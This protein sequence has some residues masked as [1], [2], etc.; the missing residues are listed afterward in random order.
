MTPPKKK[1]RTK[2]Q[3]EI[4][5]LTTLKLLSEGLLLKQAAHRLN[6]PFTTLRKQVERYYYQQGFKTLTQCV[7]AYT[8][9]A[10]QSRQSKG[11]LSASR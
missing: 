3:N 2:Q 4:V 9:V 6:I 1:Y 7:A 5:V 10:W 8:L 11:K